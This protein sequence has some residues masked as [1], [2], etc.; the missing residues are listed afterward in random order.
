MYCE[1]KIQLKDAFW[2]EKVH[3]IREKVLPY[4]WEALNDRIEGA[5]KSYCIRNFRTAARV[6]ALRRQGVTLPEQPTDDF[7][8]LPRGNALLPEHKKGDNAFYGYVFQDS[9]LYKWIEAAAYSLMMKADD[10][11][12]HTIDEMVDLLEEATLNDGYLDTFYSIKNPKKRFSNLRDHHELY[13]F[14]HLAEAAV[15]Y[16]EATGKKQLL[17]LAGAVCRSDLQNY[18]GKEEGKCHGYPGHELAE[19]ALVRLYR[20]TGKTFLFRVSKIFCAGAWQGA[21]LFS[22]RAWRKRFRY[23][24][25]S[26]AAAGA[27]ADGSGG[28][29]CAC[30]VICIPG[31]Q[32]LR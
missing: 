3:L 28:A 13:C 27:R 12:E 2:G 6:N 8:S 21:K 25:L 4:Q 22:K 31:L 7:V 26:G 1:E 14:G 20:H 11:L 19:M 29:C 16:Y 10:S 32:I 24:L 23:A 5:D 17:H 18:F 15:A 9:D 30:N